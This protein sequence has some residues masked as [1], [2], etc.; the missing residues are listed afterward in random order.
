M[1]ILSF[2][3]SIRNADGTINYREGQQRLKY[4]DLILIE[5]LKDDPR[6]RSDYSEENYRFLLNELRARCVILL[7]AALTY[8]TLPDYIEKRIPIPLYV[9]SEHVR[10]TNHVLDMAYAFQENGFIRPSHR[11]SQTDADRLYI[12]G[13]PFYERKKSYYDNTRRDSD[14]YGWLHDIIVTFPYLDL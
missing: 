4:I 14:N 12:R 7:D 10:E 2:I 13:L 1:R 8:E 9:L 11:D 6:R 3:D 5:L